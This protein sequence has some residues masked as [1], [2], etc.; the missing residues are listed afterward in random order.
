K[1]KNP[2]EFPVVIHYRVAN[3]EALVEILGKPRPYDKIVFE[4]NILESSPYPTEERLDDTMPTETTSIDQAG[5]NGYKL[6]R[7]RRFYKD[8]KLIKS[9][10]WTVEY[11]PVTEYV[12]RGT[13]TDPEAKPPADK[14]VTRLQ[15]PKGDKFSMAQ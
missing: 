4:R 15:E 1:L 2:Y 13:S 9:N 8:G 10:K 7:L 11:K 12:R 5:V 14:P 3:G 6:E